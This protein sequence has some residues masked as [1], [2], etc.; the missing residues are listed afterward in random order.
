MSMSMY[1]AKRWQHFLPSHLCSILSSAREE[2]G[3]S[4]K[5]KEEKRKF[6][7]WKRMPCGSVSCVCVLC[8]VLCIWEYFLI[9]L[10]PLPCLKG[11]QEERFVLLVAPG[12][13]FLFA[14]WHCQWSTWRVTWPFVGNFTENGQL[15]GKCLR[16]V[17][18]RPDGVVCDMWTFKT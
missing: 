18:R 15:T 5:G 11:A 13:R 6:S 3:V 7:S 17:K 10:H 1:L 9:L 2:K 12:W 16:A 4:E 14:T 8:S